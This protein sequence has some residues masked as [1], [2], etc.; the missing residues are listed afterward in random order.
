LIV[1]HLSARFHVTSRTAEEPRAGNA[2][3]SNGRIRHLSLP[4]ALDTINGAIRF[5]SHGIQLDE[6]TA[7]M[8]GGPIQF[9]GRV[10]LDG[11]L[12]GE[13]NVLVSGQDMHLRY[14]EGIQSTV[15]VDLALRGNMKAPVIGGTV[16]VQSAVWTRRLDAPGSIFD[17]A[18][19]TAS[20]SDVTPVFNDMESIPIR[21]DLEIRAPSAFRMDT[22]LVQLTASADLTLQG[23][24]EKPILLGR[25]DVDRGQLNFEGRRYRVTRGSVDFTNR[26][27]IEPFIDAEG[28][29]NVRVPGQTTAALATGTLDGSS[30][31]QFDP[32]LPEAEVAAL[33][34]S[35][36]G[37]SLSGA[38][39]GRLQDRM[40]LRTTSC[41]RATRLSNPL[42]EVQRVAKQTFGVDTFR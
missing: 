3:I 24:Y 29:T 30:E 1:Y 12:P 34:L 4:N 20:S 36:A 28:E 38:G 10:N 13:L 35:D 42:V 27:R 26:A 25:A 31:A 41:G 16:T 2:I 21:F 37:G 14:P 32:P 18:S 22:N 19:R 33:L 6:V 7:S 15:D 8:G 39:A 40:A 11:Y 9:G 5:D 23:T 17:L